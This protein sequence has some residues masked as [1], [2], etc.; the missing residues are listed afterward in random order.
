MT[1]ATM[2]TNHGTIELELFDEDAPKTVENFT[3]L[4]SD[5][6][7]D[8]VVFHRV[9]EDFMIQGGDPTGTG[10]G[11]P[12]YQ[13]EDEFNEHAVVSAASTDTDWIL[14]SER[15]LSFM[16]VSTCEIV[17][18]TSI[19]DVTRPKTV[20]RPSSHGQA[21]AVTMKNW[22]PF[23]FGPAFAIARAPRSTGCLLISSSNWYPGPPMPVPVGSPPWIMKFSITRWKTTP[24]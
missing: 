11:G 21:S 13:F 3:K 12:G 1:N 14:T 17:S 8:G 6:F 10:S 23:V 20:C 22:E 15:G 19:P 16:S 24:S 7:Y 9:I 4:A 5:G 2:Q 18:T